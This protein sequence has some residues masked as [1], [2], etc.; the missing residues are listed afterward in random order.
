MANLSQTINKISQYFTSNI[1]RTVRIFV[2]ILC[3]ISLI[4]G[5]WIYFI[6]FINVKALSTN[7]IM[8]KGLKLNTKLY[9]DVNANIEKADLVSA[10]ETYNDPFK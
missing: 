6:T 7:E 8:Q 9:L 1:S 3:L 2:I 4:V 5:L 10:N